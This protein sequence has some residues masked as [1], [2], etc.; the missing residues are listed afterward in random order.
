VAAG[1]ELEV[2]EG[3]DLESPDPLLLAVFELSVGVGL[4]AVVEVVTPGE[5][6]PTEPGEPGLEPEEPGVWTET[7]PS[8]P[9]LIWMGKPFPMQRCVNTAGESQCEYRRV[10]ILRISYRRPRLGYLE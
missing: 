8:P 4:T 10:N 3:S 5:P 2:E 6:E 1:S 7:D 9:M